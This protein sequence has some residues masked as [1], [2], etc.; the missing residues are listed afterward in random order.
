MTADIDKLLPVT[1]V[2][3][4]PRPLWYRHQLHGQDIRHA[5]MLEEHAQAYEDATTAVIAEQHEAGLDVV[6]DGQMYFDD[7]GGSI[8][9]FCWYWYE[10]LPGFNPVKMPHPG[11]IGEAGQGQISLENAEMLNNWGATTTT[12]EI[13]RGPVRLAELYRIA[14]RHARRPLKASV[15]A[16]P[17]NLAMH[18]YYDDQAYY[19][20]DR[21]LVDALVPVFNA[22]LR[23]LVAA[24]ARF[25]QLED[26]GVWMPAVEGRPGD[27]PWVVDVLNR[28]LEGV[29]ARVGLHFCL[30]THYGNT[31]EV[32]EGMLEQTLAQL[33]GSGIDQFVLDF[34]LRDMQDVGAMSGLPEDKEVAVGVIDVRVLQVETPD[35]VAARIRKALE[36]VPAEQVWLTTDCGMRV[37]PR[38]VARQKIRAL[39]A[40]AAIVRAELTG[41]LG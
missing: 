7:Y 40:G 27:W 34:A 25:I 5:F 2:G 16:G 26:L 37:L 41:A 39:V 23:E 29:D 36:I 21:S 11:A 28:V 3:S 35:V 1:M 10:R 17:L 30:G 31:A 8:G 15:G 14:S 22:E 6:T 24:G 4:W 19:K 38:I 32:F 13:E 33:Y 12:G 9:S 20:D 18:V